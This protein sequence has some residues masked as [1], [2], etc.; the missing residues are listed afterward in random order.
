M[1]VMFWFG[2]DSGRPISRYQRQSTAGSIKGRRPMVCGQVPLIRR[3]SSTRRC[4][5]RLVDKP[6]TGQSRGRTAPVN[7]L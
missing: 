3:V 5:E 4:E 6:F 2:Q 7:P 1:R